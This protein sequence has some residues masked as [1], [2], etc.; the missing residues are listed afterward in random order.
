M[1]WSMLFLTLFALACTKT[2]AASTV[3]NR[4]EGEPPPAASLESNRAAV[5]S[6][7]YGWDNPETALTKWYPVVGIVS[8]R[9]TVITSYP[10]FELA[11]LT[12]EEIGPPA[13]VVVATLDGNAYET[14]RPRWNASFMGTSYGIATVTAE[15]LPHA[16][17]TRAY[18]PEKRDARYVLALDGKGLTQRSKTWPPR[19]TVTT[20]AYQRPVDYGDRSCSVGIRYY[21]DPKGEA[22]AAF[23]EQHELIGLID[24]RVAILPDLKQRDPNV[25]HDRDWSS[26]GFFVCI[27]IP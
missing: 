18:A 21:M 17:I 5:V 24:G 10:P 12:P 2:I 9:E 26:G 8:A 20:V 4:I 19:V 11:W 7:W 13:H 15:G 1:R 14:R 3:E 27:A 23:D 25:P 22:I 6:V 16:P